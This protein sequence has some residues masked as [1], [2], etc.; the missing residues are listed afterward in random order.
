MLWTNTLNYK[1]SIIFYIKEKNMWRSDHTAVYDARSHQFVSGSVHKKKTFSKISSV[2]FSPAIILTALHCYSPPDPL[3][4]DWGPHTLKLS[5]Q[6][7]WY[8][9]YAALFPPKWQ[10]IDERSFQWKT[11]TK[12]MYLIYYNIMKRTEIYFK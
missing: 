8:K 10:V 6:R 1:I 11:N 2:V 5:S 4:W 3:H 7:K 9:C 12:N